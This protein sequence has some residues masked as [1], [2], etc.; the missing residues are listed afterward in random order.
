MSGHRRYSFVGIAAFRWNGQYD[1][2]ALQTGEFI[3]PPGLIYRID[4][5]PPTW[6]EIL[7]G[8]TEVSSAP[9]ATSAPGAPVFS[10][11]LTASR[12][13]AFPA[14]SCSSCRNSS[15]ISWIDAITGPVASPKLTNAASESCRLASMV[16]GTASVTPT[17]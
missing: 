11:E 13:P 9:K 10:R 4:R 17:A 5:M 12:R 7:F 15:R 3:L 2:D 14:A 8:S 1:C 16:S 6:R